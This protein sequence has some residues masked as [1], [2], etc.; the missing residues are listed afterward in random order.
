MQDTEG[1]Q[2][3]HRRRQRGPGGQDQRPGGG[4][5]HEG[6][7]QGGPRLRGLAPGGTGG[8]ITEEWVSDWWR[9][10]GTY[11]AA[12]AFTWLIE[13]IVYLAAFTALG[14]FG[15]DPDRRFTV[16]R[17]LLLVLAV[18]LVSH[19]PLWLLA[20]SVDGLAAVSIG[21]LAVVVL[22]GSL[23]A[24]VLRGSWRWACAAALLANACSYLAGLVGWLVIVNAG[25]SAA[26]C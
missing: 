1:D 22:E 12:F 3:Q 13:T 7:K 16:R 8:E 19:P 25:G 26:C 4:G 14:L 15:P 6:H 24:L 5:E 23:I 17:A 10:G 20:S 2:P 18:N 21:E 11:A 9:F